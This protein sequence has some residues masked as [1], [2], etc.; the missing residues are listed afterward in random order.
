MS[1]PA[2][3]DTPKVNSPPS[4]LGNQLDGHGV[5]IG[6]TVTSHPYAEGRVLREAR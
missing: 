2:E 3:S 1:I 5:S 6:A 4:R